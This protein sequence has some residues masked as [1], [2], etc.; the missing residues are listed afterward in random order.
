MKNVFIQ[1]GLNAA[2]EYNYLAA[3]DFLQRAENVKGKFQAHALLLR[4]VKTPYHVIGV[5]IQ[6]ERN[7]KL[8]DRFRSNRRIHILDY[9]VWSENVSQ[10]ACGRTTITKAQHGYTGRPEF[11]VAY[12]SEAI[13]LQRLFEIVRGLVGDSQV[14]CVHMN[15]EGAEIDVLRG[16]DWDT[17]EKPDILRIAVQHGRNKAIDTESPAYC[18]DVLLA[19]GYRLENQPFDGQEYLTFMRNDLMETLW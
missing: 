17:F 14:R 7:E 16:I 12:Q 6:T 15:I 8:R 4:Q 19:G 10:L 9:A 5:D 11:T 13:T 18:T 1:I 3:D 2:L